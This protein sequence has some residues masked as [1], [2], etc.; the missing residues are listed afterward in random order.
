MSAKATESNRSDVM[1][2]MLSYGMPCVASARR[3]VRFA[4]CASMPRHIRVASDSAP[5]GVAVQQR[6]AHCAHGQKHSLDHDGVG[7][8]SAHSH[9]QRTAQFCPGAAVL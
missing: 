1:C 4:V 8:L 2:S 6:Q 7:S 9:P 5:E 3:L